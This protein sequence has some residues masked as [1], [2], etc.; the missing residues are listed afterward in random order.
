MPFP[1][2]IMTETSPHK[3]LKKL[4][5]TNVIKQKVFSWYSPIPTF[6]PQTAGCCQIAS[7]AGNDVTG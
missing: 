2:P 1:L 4:N 5:V 7:G 6:K 3:D